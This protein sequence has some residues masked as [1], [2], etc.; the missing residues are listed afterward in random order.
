MA[1]NLVDQLGRVTA[2]RL[3]DSSFAQFQA[4]RGVSGLAAQIVQNDTTLRDYTAR[5]HCDLGDFAEYAG[6]R[7]QL[8]HRESELARQGARDRRG[9]VAASL[10]ALRRGDVIRIAAGRRAGLAVVLD[11]GVQPRDDPHPLVVTERRWG[12]RLSLVDFPGAVD[13]LGRVRLPD[14]AN[15]RDPAERRDIAARIRSLR[16]PPANGRPRRQPTGAAEDAELARL[17]AALRAHPC[18]RC[19]DRDQHARWSER[20]ARLAR[21]N[22]GLRR[23]IDGRRGSLGRMFDSICD[24]LEERGYLAGE[25]TTPGGRLLA[26]IWSESDLVVAEC[27]RAGVWDG[28]EPAELAAVVSTMVYESRREENPPD[29]LPGDSVEEALAATVRIWS[30]V[31]DSEQALGLPQT[32]VPEAGFAWPVYRW[33]RGEPL[34]RALDAAAQRGSE[35]PPGDFIRWCKQVVDLLDQIAA[36]PLPAGSDVPVGPAARTAARA[37]RRGVVAQSLLA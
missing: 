18:H 21:E 7:Q 3:L 12:G 13:V 10:E 11:P 8:S 29:R 14:H 31:A 27:L 6:L 17:R 15:H 20:A 22:D 24:L 1:V 37:I 23:R 19:P 2:R 28:L 4:D 9:A 35:L 32:R 16:I 25:E 30:S 26:R 5:M 34:R 36:A 33:A